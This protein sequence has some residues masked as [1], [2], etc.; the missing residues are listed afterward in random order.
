MQIR[1]WIM[2]GSALC[3]LSAFSGIALAQSDSTTAPQTQVAQNE[4]APLA[5][6]G[7]TQGIET[8]V[9]TATLRKESLQDT[10]VAVTALGP[11]QLDKL[12]VKDLSSLTRVAPN[13]TIE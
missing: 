10:P 13:V 6:P 12:F 9:V 5:Q 4:V 2:C 8:V 3:A 11:E 1:Q 7:E